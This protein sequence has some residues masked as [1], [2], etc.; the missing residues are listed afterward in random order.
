MAAG[1]RVGINLPTL[2]DINTPPD[3]FSIFPQYFDS[4]LFYDGADYIDRTETAY[5]SA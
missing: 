1:G 5:T 2:L 4:V 3:L